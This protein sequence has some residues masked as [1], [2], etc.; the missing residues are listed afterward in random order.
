[1]EV[2]CRRLIRAEDGFLC[3]TRVWGAAS[4][5]LGCGCRG[6]EARALAHVSPR[7][8]RSPAPW[9]EIPALP[10]EKLHDAAVASGAESEALQNSG[11]WS[12][13]CQGFPRCARCCT[14]TPMCSRHLCFLEAMQ[15]Q[16]RPRGSGCCSQGCS[17]TNIPFSPSRQWVTPEHGKLALRAGL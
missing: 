2:S 11:A 4:E 13:G 9:A 16:S 12:E 6:G 3:S 7:W 8:G 5:L 1:M 14:V 15:S 10:L 17:W